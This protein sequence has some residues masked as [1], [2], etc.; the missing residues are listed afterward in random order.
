MARGYGAALKRIGKDLAAHLAADQRAWARDNADIYEHGL[1]SPWDKRFYYVHHTDVARQWLLKRLAARRAL[2]AALDP[3]RRGIDGDWAA[4]RTT[5]AI[6]TGADGSKVS[7]SHWTADD[8]K[9][10]CDFDATVRFSAGRFSGDG[11]L[12]PL[13]LEGQTLVMGP[14]PDGQ[15]G[16]C[17][18]IRD[19]RARLLPLTRQPPPESPF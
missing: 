12:P 17:S 8:Y 15:P 5:L 9:A 6:T 7:G 18:R 1:N 10:H 16:S 2:L 3:D 19:P 14:N 11:E 4:N 13:A